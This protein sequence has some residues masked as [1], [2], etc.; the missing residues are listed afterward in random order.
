MKIWASFIAAVIVPRRAA[1]WI[2]NER[3][4]D[5]AKHAA[6]RSE[7]SEK[8]DSALARAQAAEMKSQDWENACERA[9][10]Q[11]DEERL[12]LRICESDL[13]VAKN[14]ID[15]LAGSNHALQ[16]QLLAFAVRARIETSGNPSY[17]D[18]YR[19][20]NGPSAGTNGAGTLH[21]SR[22]SLEE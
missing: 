13:A 21:L 20:I 8:L 4:K 15:G 17:D 10:A 7:L 22:E 12:K 11:V 19:A 16:Q 18:A 9:R 2:A 6:E 3:R 1:T 5:A 14:T